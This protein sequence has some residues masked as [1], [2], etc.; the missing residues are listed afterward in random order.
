GPQLWASQ[1]AAETPYSYESAAMLA[2]QRRQGIFV[3]TS[4]S[5]GAAQ[6]HHVGELCTANAWGVVLRDGKTVRCFDPLDGELL[7]QRDGAPSGGETFSDGRHLIMARAGEAKGI[8]I[9]MIDGG[10]LGEWKRPAAKWV[11]TVG[12]N[13]IT[14]IKGLRGQQ[15]RVVE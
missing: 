5:R 3:Q 7:W 15:L 10:L 2:W 9:S 11:G 6:S 14:M 12:G 1:S 8:L 4:H 13:A